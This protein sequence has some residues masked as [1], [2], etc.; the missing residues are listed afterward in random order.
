MGQGNGLRTLSR[1]QVE[2]FRRDGFLVVD[3]LLDEADVEPVKARA[4]RIAAGDAP[5]VPDDC[6]QIEPALQAGGGP[7]SRALAVRKLYKLAQVDDVMLAHVRNPKLV[8]AV[9][10]LLGADDI[11]LYLDQI[12]MKPA[13]HGS[14]QA[15]HQDSASWRDIFPMDLVTAWCALDDATIANGCLWMAPGTHRWGMIPSHLR[16]WVESRLVGEFE[17]VPVE[18]PA[19]GVSFHHSLVLHA[20]RPNTTP[21]RRRG[22]AVHYMRAASIKDAAVTDAPKVPPF[23]Q[24]RGRSFPGCV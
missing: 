7:S 14:A 9:A 13:F 12:L 10:D 21:H 20:S 5:H 15:W 23:V 24:I 17:P 6:V 11:K 1:Q 8:D 3:D 16:P 18:I 4:E 22:A 19:G 2:Q